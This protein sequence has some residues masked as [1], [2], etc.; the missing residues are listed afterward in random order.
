LASIGEHVAIDD[1]WVKLIQFGNDF[2]LVVWTMKRSLEHIRRTIAN[3]V[4]AEL[5]GIATSIGTILGVVTPAIEAL[6]GIGEHVNIE[7]LTIKLHDFTTQLDEAVTTLKDKFVELAGTTGG[8][9]LQ[10]ASNFAASAEAML[11]SAVSIFTSLNDLVSADVPEGLQAILAAMLESLKA[12]VTP[13]YD[14]GVEIGGGIMR[15]IR[16]GLAAGLADANMV[17]MS[18]LNS[19]GTPGASAGVGIG[20]PAVA[21]LGTGNAGMT[22]NMG[23]LTFNT[24]IN[25][26][27]TEDEFHFRVVESVRRLM[28]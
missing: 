15:G 7:N 27:M 23:G 18:L 19:L 28:P 14:V 21:G 26:Q 3:E 1:L 9:G 5:A 17:I 16:D 13:A 10:A 6:A 22:L 4:L 8:E 25:D 11:R 24:T 2:L 12:H 20:A